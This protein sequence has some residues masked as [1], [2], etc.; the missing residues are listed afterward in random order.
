MKSSMV[1][2]G[3]ALALA[4]LFGCSARQIQSAPISS[5]AIGSGTQSAAPEVPVI[6]EHRVQSGAADIDMKRL[7]TLNTKA[8]RPT[9]GIIKG[10][11]QLPEAFPGGAI[12]M[13]HVQGFGFS[14][15]EVSVSRIGTRPYVIMPASA[16]ESQ[17][18]ESSMNQMMDAGIRF[19]EVSLADAAKIIAAERAALS[20]KSF[21][22]PRQTLPSGID[23]LL[24]MERG[25]GSYG[26]IYVGRVIRSK[27]GQLL[28]LRTENDVGPI[29]MGTLISRLVQDSL[30]RL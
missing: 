14:L 22:F 17:A 15:D 9:F 12:S 29:A 23:L 16:E 7:S 13:K 10:F 25:Y 21:V 2:L 1:F 6:P 8:K 26:P 20:K 5:S 11:Y 27:D 19:V 18:I 24:S 28:A 3:L 30:S 4:S